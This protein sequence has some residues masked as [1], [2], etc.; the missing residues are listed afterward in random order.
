[1]EQ[2]VVTLITER[3]PLTG[4]ELVDGLGHTGLALWHRCRK[5]E[6]LQVLTVGT[7]YLRLDRRV[8]GFA[9][10]SP[11]ILREF[12]TY[13]VIG[14]AGDT[15]ALHHRARKISIHLDTVSRAKWQ[16]AEQVV[17]S[18]H[19]GM[20]P[21]WPSDADLCFIVAG[22]I[23]YNMA[24]DVPRPERSTGRMVRGS[25]IDLVIV[26]HDAVPDSFLKEL[27]AQIYQQK[28]RLLVTP[29][30]N[31]ELDYIVKKMSRVHHQV[32]FST[33]KDMVACKILAE[34]HLLY[35]ST[36]LF[37]GIKAM[38]TDNGVTARLEELE[39]QAG[40]FRARTEE[41]LLT[42]AVPHAVGDEAYLFYPTEESEE[43]E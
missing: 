34:G 36:A 13:T 41:Y 8:D 42:R 12:L 38:L 7:R 37:D 2:D 20:A 17:S 35:G 6:Q 16:L 10:L 1:M 19:R 25:D 29:Q 39:R 22:D 11:S 32:R 27:D 33:F 4:S 26:A 23:V 14:L 31:E 18:I 21:L 40:A 28:Y 3:G 24:H 15:R 30:V 5:S 9:R 43:F